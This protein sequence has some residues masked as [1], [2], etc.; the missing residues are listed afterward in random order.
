MDKAIEISTMPAVYSQAAVTIL[1]SR[2]ESVRGGFLHMRN[3]YDKSIF[4]VPYRGSEDRM[5]SIVLVPELARPRN[6]KEPLALRA[7]ALQEKLLSPRILDYGSTQTRWI[8]KGNRLDRRRD[9]DGT[10][11]DQNIRE[12]FRDQIGTLSLSS[13]AGILTD[14][15]EFSYDRWYYILE[16][17]TKLHITFHSDRLLAIAGIAERWGHA[18]QDEYLVGL[19]RSRLPVEL[20][21]HIWPHTSLRRPLEYQAPSWSWAAVNGTVSIPKTTSHHEGYVGINI[22]DSQIEP[23]YN[24]INPFQNVKYGAVKSGRIILKG[25]GR[26]AIL[27]HTGGEFRLRRQDASAPSPDSDFLKVS[28]RLDAVEKEFQEG[29][30]GSIL[31]F[32][33]KL[34]K[35]SE[36]RRYSWKGLILRQVSKSGYSRLGIFELEERLG[37]V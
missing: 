13:N 8:C 10:T 16:G 9:I 7:W 11:S 12:S 3:P 18:L 33:L 6:S 2:A 27:T 17:Y 26:T 22:L 20:L 34:S 24:I 14:H 5:A 4:E 23:L 32:L 25:G 21:W 35:T 19:W 36:L 37:G 31:V 29:N 15:K 28:I 30:N 1:A